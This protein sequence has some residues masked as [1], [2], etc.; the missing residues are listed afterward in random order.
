MAPPLTQ[1]GLDCADGTLPTAWLLSW[2][3]QRAAAN[4]SPTLPG[5]SSA[6]STEHGARPHV[7]DGILSG[8]FITY[9]LRCMYTYTYIF[10]SKTNVYI[11]I[12]YIYIIYIIIKYCKNT[13]IHTY[14]HT[15]KQ[16]YIHT[17]II[18]IL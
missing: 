11:N 4:P 8:Y 18:Y 5:S 1:S 13:Y 12:I 6:Q 3:S 9:Y 2:R 14:V 10:K 17:Y 16:T 15:Y 7:R